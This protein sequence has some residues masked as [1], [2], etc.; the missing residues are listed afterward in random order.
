[1]TDGWASL[2]VVAM[3]FGVTACGDAATTASNVSAAAPDVSSPAPAGGTPLVYACDGGASVTARYPD[4]D[5]AVVT[6]AGRDTTLLVA[7]SGSG[8][9][10]VGGEYE[11]LTATRDGQQQGLL[12]RVAAGRD[13]EV[14]ERCSRPA[15]APGTT[16]PAPVPQ[17]EPPPACPANTLVAAVEGSD[18]G[19]GNRVTVLSLQ[20]T[21]SRPCSLDGY[22]SVRLVGPDA[23]GLSMV[24]SENTPGS[25]F[26]TGQPTK[27]VL[28]VQGK[29]FF[30]VAWSAI[31]HENLG[32]TVCPAATGLRITP[33]E[34]SDSVALPVDLQP[35]GRRL[36]ISPLR[37]VANPDQTGG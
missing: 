19:A 27:V 4:A 22:P 30:D 11:W 7:P 28:S 15:D 23:D 3:A 5:T 33:P 34:G 18:A 29:A 1:M 10:Y 17:S 26:R 20:N 25:Y 31:P 37:P 32:E 21:G 2:C 8:V 16:A 24:R 13:P 36:R 35:C 14:I 9:R 12:S 6:Y